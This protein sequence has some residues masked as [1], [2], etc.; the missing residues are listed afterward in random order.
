MPD[1]LGDAIL[2]I[3]AGVV[4]WGRFGPFHF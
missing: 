4:V 3:L 1:R 2:A